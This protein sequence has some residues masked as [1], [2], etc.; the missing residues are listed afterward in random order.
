M[1][2]H[3]FLLGVDRLSPDMNKRKKCFPMSV[4]GFIHD[5][6]GSGLVL[7]PVCL[8]AEG[9][10]DHRGGEERL[11]VTSKPDSLITNAAKDLLVY[12]SKPRALLLPSGDGSY[13]HEPIGP[14]DPDTLLAAAWSHQFRPKSPLMSLHA[15]TSSDTLHA[16]TL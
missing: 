9:H 12:Q 16:Y 14:C 6:V 3:D 4:V 5:S 1:L 11:S 13:Y 2:P 10:R 8:C 7:K 15:C